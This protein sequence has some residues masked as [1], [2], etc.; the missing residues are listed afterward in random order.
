M[1]NDLVKLVE[2]TLSESK[3]QDDFQEDVQLNERFHTKDELLKGI[4]FEE[5]IDT[6]QSNESKYDKAT[7][8][9]VFNEILKMKL[10]D[11]KYELKSKMSHILKNL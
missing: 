4:T 10:D 2:D 8:T 7:V 6:V 1:K 5:L 9:K 3:L 11:A